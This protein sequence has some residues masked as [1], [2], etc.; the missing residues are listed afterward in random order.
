MQEVIEELLLLRKMNIEI[1]NQYLYDL[2]KKEKDR[3]FHAFYA[4][5]GVT[6][7]QDFEEEFAEY[8]NQT[9]NKIPPCSGHAFETE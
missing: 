8:Y 6:S 7:N 2:L 4:G 9:Y 3:M 1:S 5:G